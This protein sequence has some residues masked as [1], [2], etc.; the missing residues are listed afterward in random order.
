MSFRQPRVFSSVA[1]P[2]LR[3]ARSAWGARGN[4]K[5][6]SMDFWYEL[7]IRELGDLNEEATEI[8][9]DAETALLVPSA[10]EAPARQIRADRQIEMEFD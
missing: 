3:V 9:K 4:T 2:L 10:D 7:A 6:G 5:G 1:R 8:L